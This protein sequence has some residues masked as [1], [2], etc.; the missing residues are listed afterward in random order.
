MRK[1]ISFFTAAAILSCFCFV[2][3][4]D[5]EFTLQG[6]GE[7][8]EQISVLEPSEEAASLKEENNLVIEEEDDISEI[9]QEVPPSSE[10]D[11]FTE[12]AEVIEGKEAAKDAEVIKDAD[13]MKDAEVLR[14]GPSYTLHIPSS[15]P[16]AY[17]CDT[18]SIGT[19]SITDVMGYSFG[20]SICVTIYYDG[21]FQSL[22]TDAQIPYTIYAEDEYGSLELLNSGDSVSFLVAENGELPKY[23]SVRNSENH[24][25]NL[26]VFFPE[27]AWEALSSGN[28]STEIQF[29]DSDSRT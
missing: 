24:V 5:D 10:N 11:E 12:E 22:S 29:V 19:V 18:C 4:A 21:V 14:A 8:D 2:G 28:Y 27:D 20:D 3:F 1:I 23:G 16:I 7:F 6:D 17:R 25:V 26:I 9:S 13:T 15:L